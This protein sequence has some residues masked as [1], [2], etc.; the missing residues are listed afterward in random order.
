MHGLHD[1]RL[2]AVTPRSTA[3]PA[4]TNLCAL[5]ERHAA[6]CSAVFLAYLEIPEGTKII[7][8]CTGPSSS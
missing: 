2:L 7:Q 6:F 5:I 8:L 3:L 4:A 1:D